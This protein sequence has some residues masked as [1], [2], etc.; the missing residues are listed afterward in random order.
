MLKR[1][2][3]LKRDDLEELRKR[4]EL[5]K[6]HTL[7]AQAL[8]Y[9]KQLYIQQLFPRYGLDPNKQF[10]INL[11]TGRVSEEITGKK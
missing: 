8:E 2:K 4:E 1:A 5:I 11:K 9:Q 7:I 3:K 10:N 6:Q